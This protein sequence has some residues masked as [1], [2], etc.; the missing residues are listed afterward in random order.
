MPFPA[1]IIALGTS[2][3]EAIVS[4]GA[5][6]ALSPVAV[7]AKDKLEKRFKLGKYEAIERA[8]NG[9]KD[10]LFRNCKSDQVETTR[11][12]IRSLDNAKGPLLDEFA[13]QVT[14][15]YL[16]PSA[17]SSAIAIAKTYRKVAGPAAILQGNVIDES[18]LTNI[19]DTFFLAYRERLIREKDFA[20]LR[21]YFQLAENRQQTKIQQAMLERLDDIATNTSRPVEDFS[22]VRREYL[23]YLIK[24]FTIPCNPWFCATSWR[25]SSQFVAC[26]DLSAFA[27]NRGA[28]CP[29]R[30]C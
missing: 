22:A 24:E 21:D 14:H 5:E 17:D 28:P 3:A 2:L 29:C 15:T 12:V 18:T 26:Q 23:E 11:Q 30:I 25:T 13:T 4:K 10:D 9:A 7:K 16:L 19:L 20:H 27:S 6:V 1:L 8:L